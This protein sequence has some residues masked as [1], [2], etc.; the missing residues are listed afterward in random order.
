MLGNQKSS[1]S[2][3]NFTD[4]LGSSWVTAQMQGQ[5]LFHPHPMLPSMSIL[6][7]QCNRCFL[8]IF[9]WEGKKACVNTHNTE[10]LLLKAWMYLVWLEC[11][12]KAKPRITGVS[13]FVHCH[14]DIW[15]S[16]RD[17]GVSIL[18][19]FGCGGL[20]DCW[21]WSLWCFGGHGP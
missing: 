1:K 18:V 3:W 16:G 4:T 5:V 21:D 19:L 14:A 10:F 8:W 2:A 12:Q 6:N 7:F 17:G 13:V 20:E 15:V 11:V 9:V